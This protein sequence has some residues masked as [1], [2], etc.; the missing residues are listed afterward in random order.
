MEFR[1]LGAVD[2]AGDHGPVSLGG[3][4]RRLLLALL[5]SRAPDVFLADGLV[6]ALWE[7]EPPAAAMT[8]LHAQVSR[9]RGLLEPGR[10]PRQPSAVLVSVEG[11]YRLDL[12]GQG[13][14][15]RRF[16]DLVR[17]ARAAEEPAEAKA[18]L[19]EAVALWRGPAYG[20]LA[21]HPE[22]APVAAELEGQRLVAVEEL[23]DAR[24]RLGEHDSLVAEL[25]T[26]VRADP[27]RERIWGQLMLALYR[28]GRQADAL[29]TYQR[30]RRQLDDELGIEPGPDLRALEQAV[31]RQSTELVWRP[32]TPDRPQTTLAHHDLMTFVHA[33]GTAAASGSVRGAVE[34]LGGEIVRASGSRSLLVRFESPAAAVRAAVDLVRRLP[35]SSSAVGVAVH[36]GPAVCLGSDWFGPAVDQVTN[37]GSRARPTQVLVSEATAELVHGRL[38]ENTSLHTLGMHR[39]QDRIA[40]QR[41]YQ[42]TGPDLAGL[43]PPER[44]DAD[45]VGLPAEVSSF[46]G[47]RSE[48]VDIAERLRLT[49]LLTLVGPGG[50]G[51][52]RLALRAAPQALDTCPDGVLF[53]DL[54]PIEDPER[55]AGVVARALRLHV[56]PGRALD[57]VIVEYL[58]GRQMLLVL[59]NCEHLV[60]PLVDFIV[61]VLQSVPTIRVLATSRERLAIVGESTWLTPTLTVPDGDSVDAV[62][63]SEAGR[64]FIDRARAV[65]PDFAVTSADARHV[66]TICRRL[67]GLPLAIELAAARIRVL[68]LIGIAERLDDR[69]RLLG[70]P[71]RSAAPRQRTLRAVIDW[72]YDQLGAAER[73]TLA[74]LSVFAGSFS[75]E[76]VE[77][78]TGQD[79]L[80]LL[81]EL[82]DKSLVHVVA[83]R[84]VRYRLLETIRAYAAERLTAGSDDDAVKAVHAEFFADLAYRGCR[85]LRG[86]DNL[87]WRERLDTDYENIQAA[88]AWALDN[89]PKLA[90]RMCGAMAEYWFG[91]HLYDEGHSLVVAALGSTAADT[92]ARSMALCAAACLA[93]LGWQ[94]S[95]AAALASQAREL[96]Q[97]QGDSRTEAWALIWQALSQ[98]D[99]DHLDEAIA[100]ATALFGVADPSEP[101]VR[102]W[103]LLLEWEV[104]RMKGDPAASRSTHRLCMDAARA[105]GDRQAI[106]FALRQRARLVVAD[107]DHE[108]AVVSLE[109]ALKLATEAGLNRQTL[110]C[111]GNLGHVNAL[112]GDL[113]AARRYA[114]EGLRLRSELGVRSHPPLVLLMAKL[115]HMVGDVDA[116]VGRL[117]GLLD[118]PDPSYASS[119]ALLLGDIE[120]LDGRPREA[121]Q[122][123]GAV[124]RTSQ[125][126]ERAIAVVGAIAARAELGE[127]PDPAALLAAIDQLHSH[128]SLDM[129]LPDPWPMALAARLLAAS[130]QQAS[131]HGL[132]SGAADAALRTGQA[133]PLTE[134]RVA[135]QVAHV[136]G[137]LVPQAAARLLAAATA[138]RDRIG[139]PRAPL[140]ERWH[141]NEIA[142]LGQA[143]GLT[144][145]GRTLDRGEM[146]ELA[147]SVLRDIP[148]GRV[149]A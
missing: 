14:D 91:R 89:D 48:L 30:C 12:A 90:L 114:E 11:G 8:V 75:L 123:F 122:T 100:A 148:P 109:N 22:L 20:E 43:D 15:A 34:R 28:C 135:E 143:E 101:W 132:L 70:V 36:A 127:P 146:L 9:L 112:G 83:G 3:R 103:G 7:G 32:P 17:R 111:L 71:Y 58:Q 57:E 26:A 124:A 104:L 60:G 50:S 77:A 110:M 98:L 97:A 85:A 23:T 49:R 56:D 16:G 81:A 21:S 67:D 93:Y 64:L 88:I 87:E 115:D 24:L 117:R 80:D 45:V 39:V 2:V 42:V 147:R 137:G 145:D 13:V 74:A 55:L 5:V 68:G 138:N 144:A 136:G 82:V 108:A 116:A 37:L 51:K 63:R 134:V 35:D 128:L 72:S 41:I 61:K 118:S 65:A 52:T 46:V 62:E 10:R 47:R 19:V 129:D 78:V 126:R 4:Q 66:A 27:F 121:L 40:I 131:A 18:L 140:E 53:V 54:A 130:G 25:E 102:A 31:L 141:V 29:A 86:P 59:D 139:M 99:I 1:V 106:I 73:R 125:G 107:R 33:E 95:Q 142:S 76:A 119:A 44:L 92:P 6:D 113:I 120:L 105:A 96:A 69:F 79:A 38:P 149:R 133:L 84:E 94:H